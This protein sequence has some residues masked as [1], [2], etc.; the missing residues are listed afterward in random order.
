MNYRNEQEIHEAIHAA[1]DALQALR[2]AD[3]SLSGASSWGLW[4]MLG[5]GFI[6]TMLKHDKIDQARREMDEARKALNRFRNE[7]A[8][9]GRTIEFDIDL[10]GFLRFADYF[11]D[12]FV[13]D[14]MVQSKIAQARQKVQQA[15]SVVDDIRSR[16]WKML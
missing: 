10:G 13:S 1:D 7:L 11:F 12:D 9:L 3:S 2:A 4:D 14:W 15:M 6:S 5:G 16:L 8:D